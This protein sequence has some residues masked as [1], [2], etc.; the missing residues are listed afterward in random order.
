M[1][2]AGRRAGS[3]IRRLAL[4]GASALALVCA[5]AS[6]RA[7]DQAADRPADAPEIEMVAFDE[8]MTVTAT[9]RET[10]A[11]VFP[12]QVSVIDRDTINDF[13]VSSV[14]DLFDLVPGA[15]FDGGPRRSG[16]VPTVRGQAGES[17]LVLIDGAR[18]SFIS[19]H[20]GRFFID[21]TLLKAVE[22]VRGPNSALYGSS[23]LGGVIALRTVDAADILGDGDTYGFS[24]DGSF[25]GVNQE[26][27][28]T[29]TFAFAS[30]DGRFDAV[31][32]LTYRDSGDIELG[33]D[34]TL[35]ADDEILSGL[36]KVTLR[37]RDGI[38]FSGSYLAFRQDGQDPNN[39]QLDNTANPGNPLV[40]RRVEGDTVQ[41][42]LDI[43]P[44]GNALVDLSAVAYYTRNSVEEDEIGVPQVQDRVVETLGLRIDNRSAFR[45]DGGVD[46][47]FT[48]GVEIYEDEQTGLDTE[49]EDGTRGG[50]PDA[51]TLFYGGYVQAELTL[52]RPLG[53]PGTLTA[54]PALR[55][56]RFE[57]ENTIEEGVRADDRV[58]PKVGVSYEPTDW[59][60]LFGNYAEAFR[61]PSFNELFADGIHFSLPAFQFGPMGP[62]VVFVNNLFIPN[63]TLEPEISESWEIGA[64][65]DFG[66]LVFDGDRLTVKGSYYDSR[67]T[68][69][70]D[71]EVIIPPTCNPDPMFGLPLSPPCFA[72]GTSQNINTRNADID[73]FELDIRY[74]SPR[75]YVTANA[76]GIN[77]VDADTG[78]F[79]GILSPN[80]YFFDMG[81]R[82]PE[83]DV[84]GGVRVTI[85][86]EFTE[87]NDPAQVRDG[88]AVLDLYAI[89]T[90]LD[91]P[92][93][94]LRV[95]LGVDNVT[96]ADFN[97]VFAGV[98]QPGRNYKAAVRWQTTW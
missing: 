38:T 90:P 9:R 65:L 64:G 47:A 69:L 10:E 3:D 75:F 66:G 42:R 29:S 19:G 83:I 17:V 91:G 30:P 95:D 15:R 92:L 2:C 6:A 32:S 23:A 70:I 24:I 39:P 18:Q 35:P 31:G 76:S 82:V 16:E 67:V 52:T 25:F 8:I 63:D 84:R 41:G 86:E 57:S 21:P 49:T 1:G 59:L 94:G 93:R 37:P 40:D 46:L 4:L 78:A 77:G 68:N 74:D 50:A 34:Q 43:K 51:S 96:D 72:A 87:V 28:T 45:F 58:S 89:W 11:F 98:S 71:L 54:I 88:Y 55:Y 14:S 33:N 62:E 44:A 12:G 73:G 22:V 60:L 53:L 27:K 85:G 5:S 81:T 80:I 13:L 26:Y 36:A 79:L 97:V 56:D 61:A 20:D 7:Q 48:Y